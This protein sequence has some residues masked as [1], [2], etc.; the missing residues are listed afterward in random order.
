M[1]A[2]SAQELW[3]KEQQKCGS[4][5]AEHDRSKWFNVSLI[6]FFL[7]PLIDV[8]IMALAAGRV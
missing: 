7:L 4:G 2:T 5:W 8:R 3:T 6:G 1:R